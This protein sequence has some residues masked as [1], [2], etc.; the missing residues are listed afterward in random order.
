ME[1]TEVL[2]VGSGFGGS[3]TAA[4]LSAANLDVVILERGKHYPPGSF[5]RSPHG[6]ANNVW[7]TKTQHLGLFDLW[8][9][10][11]IDALVSSG[12]GGGSLIYA[13]VLLRMEPSWFQTM[14]PDGIEHPW[15]MTRADL[16]PFYKK[17][18]AMLGA[19]V[20]PFDQP[21]YANV[22][23]VKA[24]RDAGA[25]CS[26]EAQP[27]NLAVTFSNPGKPAT[28]GEAIVGT[29][30]PDGNRKTCQMC[31]EC[32]IGCNH[33]SKNTLDHNYLADAV[34]SGAEI[35][36]LCEA[37]SIEV[38]EQGHYIV[39]YL[40]R[41]GDATK[42]P[43]SHSIRAERLV[44]AA[45]TLGTTY[46]LLRNRSALRHLS[47]TLGTK[48]SGNGD[49]LGFI[50][51]AR[52]R[53]TGR[54]K[55]TNLDSAQGPVITSAI[56]IP[57]RSEGGTGQGFYIEDGGNPEFVNWAAGVQPLP[58]A[59]KRVALVAGRVMAAKLFG[60]SRS[61]FGGELAELLDQYASSSMPLLG[62]GRDTPDG[63]MK[64]KNDDLA[65][66]WTVKTSQPYFNEVERNMRRLASAMGGKLHINPLSMLNR[67][68]TV[69]PLG[70][71]PMGEHRDEG[72]VDSFGRVFGHDR[73]S[74][75]D[76]SILP[77]PAGANPALTIA[78]LAERATAESI[79]Q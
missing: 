27:V 8:S 66:D 46:F 77:G 38:T 28:R 72:V 3:V 7:D 75:A 1:H 5:P 15:P 49:L 67:V 33:G 68:I 4:R 52:T 37:I 76:G 79:R 26:M 19:Q 55:P 65:I 43:V 18:E 59:I 16:D 25:A 31:G 12:V 17:A 11:G 53:E 30:N 47:P 41:R 48:F 74:I 60:S 22:A 71:C 54:W 34:N 44:L 61:R 69:H 40:D 20:Y 10:S 32:D 35:R 2:V 63:I 64:L 50:S 45:G 23:K 29:R 73:L 56:R 70:G 58:A 78:A 14:G 57:D 9:F 51:R 13:N 21:E 42:T 24:F 62:M 39:T 6:L 36:D